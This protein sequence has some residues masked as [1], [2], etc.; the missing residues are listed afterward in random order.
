[1]TR[2]LIPF[3]LLICSAAQAFDHSAWN[4]LLATHVKPLRGGVAT[5][6]DYQG[7]EKDRQALQGYLDALSGVSRADYQQW[8]KDE[9][10]AF[11][12]NAYNAFTVELI[13]VEGQPASIRDIGSF[14]SGPWDKEFFTLLDKP[15]T[16]DEVEHE[17]IRGNPALMDPR[18]HFAVNC[19]SIGCPA[20]RPE[21]YTA[22]K[23]D[24]QL[25]DSA[26]KFLS[27]K[28][29]NRFNNDRNA[30]EISK[31]FDWYEKDFE[32]T[33][34]SL[35]EYLLPYADELGVPEEKRKLMKADDITIRHLNYNWKLNKQ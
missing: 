1:M 29:R 24:A 18:I 30:L 9:Q 33:A 23:L 11:L 27:D 28:Q 19:A 12:I 7:M 25:E 32:N 34:G 22:D 21:A 10:L 13:L 4:T 5:A 8:S 20:L 31:I 2:F 6:M 17:M 3:L 14:F 16:L 35:A 26:K 15:R